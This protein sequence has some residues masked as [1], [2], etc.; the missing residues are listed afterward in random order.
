MENIDIMPTYSGLWTNFSHLDFDQAVDWVI[1]RTK[2][3][4]SGARREQSEEEKIAGAC[5][6]AKLLAK[7]HNCTFSKNINVNSFTNVREE[8]SL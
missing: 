5:L 8:T 6:K 3:E 7:N 2:I 1:E 4:I